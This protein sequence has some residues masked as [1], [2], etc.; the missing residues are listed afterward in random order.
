MDVYLLDTNVASALWDGLSIYHQDAVDFVHSVGGDGQIYISRIVVAEVEYGYKVYMG[1]DPT[2]K[3]I[4]EEAMKVFK[5]R[6]IDR[7]TT[8][9][10]SDIRAALFKRFSPKDKRGKVTQK[11]PETL[12]DRTTSLELG[13]QE[14]DIWTAAIA[15][16]HNMI[17]VTDDRMGRI[18]EVEPRLRCTSWRKSNSP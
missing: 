10:Y 8:G 2:R 7:H 18:R 4:I 15:V 3:Q 16:Q 5:V 17:L 13:I 11:R 14:N 9:P 1:A 12:I 6:E